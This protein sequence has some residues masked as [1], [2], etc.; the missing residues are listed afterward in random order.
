MNDIVISST[1]SSSGYGTQTSYPGTLWQSRCYGYNGG[2]DIAQVCPQ[3]NPGQ[4][5]FRQNTNV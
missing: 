3:T 4:E 5:D 1:L 2:I